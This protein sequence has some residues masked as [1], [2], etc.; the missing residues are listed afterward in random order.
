MDEINHLESG[1]R[2]ANLNVKESTEL[3]KI[4]EDE[5]R[6]LGN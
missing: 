3:L 5:L 1:L 4:A 2:E 6:K